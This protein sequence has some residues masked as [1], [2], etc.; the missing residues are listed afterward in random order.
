MTDQV[1]DTLNAGAPR[2]IA[3]RGASGYRPEHS[4]EA[5][6]LAFAQGA[7]AVE[8]DVLPSRDGVLMVRHDIDL[9]PTTDIA[10]RPEF[11]SRA[12]CI[13]GKRQWWI[14]DFDAH[15][16]EMLRCVQPIPARAHSG[17]VGSNVLRLSALLEMA[18]TAQVVV[19]IELKDTDYFRA[20]GVDPVRLLESEL[21]E[22]GALGASAPVWLECFDL[23]VLR[24]LHARCGNRSFALIESM[25]DVAQL[26]ELARWASGVA[27]PKKCLWDAKGNPTHLVAEAHAAGLEVHAWTFRDDGDCTPFATPRAEL[28]A[29]FALGVDA[30]FCDFPDT[31]LAARAQFRPGR[32]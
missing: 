10:Q 2:I 4:R 24:E 20:L 27:P 21:R 7:E 15:E 30:L 25:P 31:A 14:G 9:A 19:D 22:A 8:P 16:I 23:G 18:E 26:R 6:A 17:A 1:C 29:A 32:D 12:R 28:E 13:R 3:H 5:F 11:V